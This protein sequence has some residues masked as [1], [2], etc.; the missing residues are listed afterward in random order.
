MLDLQNK[1]SARQTAAL[2]LSLCVAGCDSASPEGDLAGSYSAERFGLVEGGT[3]ADFVAAGGTFEMVLTGDGRFSADL[4]VPDVPETERDDAFAA[5]F[6]GTYT[7]RGD[8]VV[9]FHTEDL[10]VRDLHWTTGPGTIQT[11]DTLG[12]GARFDI[13]LR[14]R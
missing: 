13:L 10:F 4:D 1:L 8:E 5:A 2:V 11:T 7:V 9:F 3:T 12:N 14:R 6:D